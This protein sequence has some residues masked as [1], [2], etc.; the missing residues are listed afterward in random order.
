LPNVVSIGLPARLVGVVDELDRG[1]PP[2][3]QAL[4][5]NAAATTHTATVRHRRTARLE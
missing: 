1:D 4:K 2:E 3:P 5:A